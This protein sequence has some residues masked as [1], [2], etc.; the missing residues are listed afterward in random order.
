[1]PIGSPASPPSAASSSGRAPAP[2]P[3]GGSG[4]RRPRS[5]RRSAGGGCWIRLCPAIADRLDRAHSA[6]APVLQAV[7]HHQRQIVPLVEDLAPDL[8]VGLAEPPDLPVLLRHQLL[9]QCGDLDVQ[10]VGGKVEV[11]SEPLRHVALAVPLQVEGLRFVAPLDLVEVQQP[12]E[13]ALA[14]MGKSNGIAWEC[15]EGARG[16][17]AGQAPPALA[18]AAG[19]GC[20]ARASEP[21]RS[22]HTLSRAMAKTPCPRWRRSTISLGESAA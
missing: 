8:R 14:G 21:A 20:L 15:V 19:P 5:G 18:K 1:M 17:G 6:R 16:V 11:G 22:S 13:L 2:C 7:L 4:M 10:V 12:G 3:S 9:V